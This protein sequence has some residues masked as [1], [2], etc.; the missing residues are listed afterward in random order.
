M[1]PLGGGHANKSVLTLAADVLVE[2]LDDVGGGARVS[3]SLFLKRV[4]L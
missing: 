2:G 4:A 3:V 1:Q